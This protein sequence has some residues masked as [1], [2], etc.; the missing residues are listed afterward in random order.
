MTETQERESHEVA[1][2]RVKDPYLGQQWAYE[3]SFCGVRGRYPSREEAG[4]GA[5]KHRAGNA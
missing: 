3:C 5:L 2:V 4:L 1:V